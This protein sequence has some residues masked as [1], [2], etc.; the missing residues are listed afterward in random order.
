MIPTIQ[1]DLPPGLPRSLADELQGKRC[2]IAIA[3]EFLSEVFVENKPL[4]RPELQQR[5][6]TIELG[7]R[8]LQALE[9]LAP[10][11]GYGTL[12][13]TGKR[14]AFISRKLDQTLPAEVLLRILDG[15]G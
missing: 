12:L 4:S 5:A 7:G 9:V 6:T 11:L 8:S 10:R 13:S 1:G 15:Q 14:H 3:V 2:D